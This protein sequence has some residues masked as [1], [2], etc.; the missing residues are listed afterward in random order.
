MNR[1][2]LRSGLLAM[3]MGTAMLAMTGPLK[4]QTVPPQSMEGLYEVSITDERGETLIFL[5]SLKR[6]ADKWVGDVRGVPVTIKDVTV[7]GESNPLVFATITVEEKTGAKTAAITIKF[8]GSKM[9][10]NLSDGTRGPKSVT[11]IKKETEGKATATIEG[12]YEFNMAGGNDQKKPLFLSIKRT[13]L[14][15]K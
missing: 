14:A 2:M 1:Q 12:T 11:G 3:L 5:V 7:A 8:E 6:D 13:K 4:P 15:D 9:I 10:L